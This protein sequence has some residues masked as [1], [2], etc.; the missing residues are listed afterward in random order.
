MMVRA[1]LML[2][3]AVVTSA[4]YRHWQAAAKFDLAAPITP[5]CAR[6]VVLGRRVDPPDRGGIYADF[7]VLVAEGI[8]YWEV[9]QRPRADSTVELK[10]SYFTTS[11]FNHDSLLHATNDRFESL[12]AALSDQ[13]SAHA[14]T[15]VTHNWSSFGDADAP[16]RPQTPDTATTV[17]ALLAF[18]D[19]RFAAM[20][21]ADTAWLRNALADDLSYA[22]SSGRRDTK[23]QFLEAIGSG[24]LRYEEFI[25]RERQARLLGGAAAAVVGLAH[26]R[27]ISAGQPVELDVRYLAVY[28]RSEGQW[29]LLAW[30]TTR[31]A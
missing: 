8:G 6:T 13:C 29:R 7:F 1:P 16:A 26:A 11:R 4:C 14:A 17:R 5:Y 27:V 22:H 18:E 24:T 23:A 9:K 19:A 3:V 12:P 25:P 28:V 2:G 15:L 10:I 21:R 20:V 30:Q 31:V